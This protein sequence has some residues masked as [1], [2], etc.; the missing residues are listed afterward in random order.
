MRLSTIDIIDPSIKE[1]NW[2]PSVGDQ[3]D[4]LNWGVKIDNV[5]FDVSECAEGLDD[6]T[7]G[8]L[9]LGVNVKANDRTDGATYGAGNISITN[10]Q[11][12][13]SA[14]RI[15]DFAVAN[16]RNINISNNTSRG[17]GDG[18]VDGMDNYLIHCSETTGKNI[19]DFDDC[20]AI[21]NIQIVGNICAD[22]DGSGAGKIDY[23]G[24]HEWGDRLLSNLSISGGLEAS[25]ITIENSDP[26]TTQPNLSLVGDDVVFRL[27]L[28]T[29]DSGSNYSSRI[30]FAERCDGDDGVMTHG[31]FIKWD[32]TADSSAGHGQ[33]AFGARDESSTDVDI[34]KI[35]RDAVADSLCVT[36]EGVGIGT[37]TPGQMLH[38][39]N[40]SDACKI[41][42][43]AAGSNDIVY[44]GFV[45]GTQKFGAGY[46]FSNDCVSLS[47]GGMSNNHLNIDAGGKVG[48]GTDPSATQTV[49]LEVDGDIQASGD[50]SAIDDLR[51]MNV[52]QYI[53]AQTDSSTGY[54]GA[55]SASDLGGGLPYHTPCS[56]FPMM[57]HTSTGGDHMEGGSL[58]S[59]SR[60]TIANTPS[61][62]SAGRTPI[63]THLPPVALFN[64]QKTLVLSLE[65]LFYADLSVDS[66]PNSSLGAFP[67]TEYFEFSIEIE[68]TDNSGSPQQ[69]QVN[70]TRCWGNSSHSSGSVA[71]DGKAVVRTKTMITTIG[72]S[73]DTL[74]YYTETENPLAW[75]REFPISSGGHSGAPYPPTMSYAVL[76]GGSNAA[77][78][79]G[80][81]GLYLAGYSYT[82]G[83][84]NYPRTIERGEGNIDIDLSLPITIHVYADFSNIALSS[85]NDFIEIMSCL[86]NVEYRTI[87]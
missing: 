13:N 57:Y 77:Q 22:N 69:V 45:D 19:F 49:E 5:I 23:D 53:G 35:D 42:I 86:L 25:S 21:N 2:N 55:E 28:K 10:C 32:G 31:G 40:D 59:D 3:G 56:T 83:S 79:S 24:N 52:Y 87:S 65:T 47:Y 67:A 60:F 70:C 82:N 8:E 72:S 78:G 4:K 75:K 34:F 76:A 58:V 12:L 64:A 30:E 48:I 51:C 27:G 41:R 46:N 73:Y 1:P 36:P 84:G 14:I 9:S 37:S 85:G 11:F 62:S 18:A 7:Y 74:S 81:G 44:M 20:P 63:G 16:I 33:F 66:A 38:I 61:I 29:T 26:S 54:F 43:E 71:E 68:F 39:K 6:A 50:I 17:S 80:T 15:D